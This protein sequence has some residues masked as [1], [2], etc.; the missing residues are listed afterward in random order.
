MLKKTIAL[1]LALLLMGSLAACGGK[2]APAS[3]NPPPAENSQE[4]Q[5]P[6]NEPEP[7]EGSQPPKETTPAFQPGAVEENTYTSDFLGL[8]LTLEEGWIIADQEQLAQLGG[9]VSE[10]IDDE[11]LRKQLADG[12]VIYDFYALNAADNSS[13]N[14]TV[15]E[16]GSLG[17]LLIDEEAYAEANL[18]ALPDAMASAGITVDKLEKTTVRLAGADRIAL[19][20]EGKVKGVPLYEVIVPVKSGACI[21]CVTAATYSKDTPPA[22]LLEPFQPR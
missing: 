9:L 12:G 20:L 21:A 18:K 11:V 7:S 2:R 6:A 4:E 3:D 22:T 8:T 16:L 14:I 5:T 15:Q 10:S 13:I 19:A 1:L 17:G